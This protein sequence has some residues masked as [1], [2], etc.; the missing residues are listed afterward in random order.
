MKFIRGV[1]NA[2]TPP[3][4]KI[5]IYIAMYISYLALGDI[6]LQSVFGLDGFTQETMLLIA[7]FGLA[8]GVEDKLSE[9]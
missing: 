5:S 2:L 1:I 4:D 8:M 3:F 7:I 6:L 9:D